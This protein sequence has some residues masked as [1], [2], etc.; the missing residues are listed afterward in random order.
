MHSA[1]MNVGG[2]KMSKS[3]GN[4]YRLSDL[5]LH[6]ITPLGFRYWLLTAHYRTQVNFTWEAVKSASD[7]YENLR[8]KIYQARNAP[9]SEYT[10]MGGNFEHASNDLNTPALIAQI[11]HTVQGHDWL[12]EIAI[13]K[14]R[15]ADAILGLKLL[16][17]IPEEITITHE[18][19]TLLDA[20]QEARA[21]KN[22]AESDRL[23]DEIKKLGYEVKDTP[24]GQKLERI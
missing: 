13:E 2:Q 1:F 18:L 9:A 8:K 16:E 21:T 17:Y 14:I 5:A 11:W 24:N 10:D 4:T 7:S 3:L 12:P 19:Q 22:Y 20:R 15:S 23:R 6:G